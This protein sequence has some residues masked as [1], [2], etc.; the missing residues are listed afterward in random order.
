MQLLYGYFFVFHSPKTAIMQCTFHLHKSLSYNRN[1][2]QTQI[3]KDTLKSIHFIEHNEE[4]ML[5]PKWIG[6]MGFPVQWKKNENNQD[7]IYRSRAMKR[8][9]KNYN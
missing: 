7:F 6:K 3:E 8:F 5:Q 4:E 9:S 1:T 2:K